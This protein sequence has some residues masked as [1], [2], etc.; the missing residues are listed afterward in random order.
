MTLVSMLIFSTG[1]PTHVVYTRD[2]VAMIGEI[3][4]THGLFL[5]AN[6]VYRELTCDGQTATGALHVADLERHASGTMAEAMIQAL[7][8]AG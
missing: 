5:L 3:A 7:L 2:E 6:E 4:C 8:R 1:N